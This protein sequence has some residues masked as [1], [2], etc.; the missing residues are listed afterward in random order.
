[1]ADTEK[2]EI[3]SAR[4]PKGAISV[5]LIDEERGLTKYENVYAVRIHSKNYVLLIMED[6]SPTL[7]QVDGNV[8]FLVDDQEV[9]FKGLKGCFKHQDNEF[10]MIVEEGA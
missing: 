2:I 1:M 7:G 3:K 10:T 4:A 5:R 9:V 6:Y 8:S